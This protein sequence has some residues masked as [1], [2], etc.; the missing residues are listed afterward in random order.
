MCHVPAPALH[1]RETMREKSI[2]KTENMLM[3]GKNDQRRHR[4]NNT[5]K[6]SPLL[7]CRWT[8][9]GQSTYRRLDWGS[10][11]SPFFSLSYQSLKQNTQ[12]SPPFAVC[13][14]PEIWV[15]EWLQSNH[16]NSRVNSFQRQLEGQLSKGQLFP[17]PHHSLPT[18]CIYMSYQQVAN[19]V[20]LLLS[21]DRGS[22]WSPPIRQLTFT[23]FHCSYRVTM[24]QREW[25][26]E[27]ISVSNHHKVRYSLI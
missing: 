24:E 23:H 14:M 4:R 17:Q 12:A 1:N 11:V 3:V 22:M 20:Q 9:E 7:T 26:K 19:I 27:K 21:W 16:C 25:N 8:F 13:F 2:T 10:S 18:A 15:M 5:L 6:S